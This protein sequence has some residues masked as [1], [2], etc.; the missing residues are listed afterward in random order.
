MRKRG[1]RVILS[2]MQPEDVATVPPAE[3]ALDVMWPAPD[4]QL[5]RVSQPELPLVSEA[6]YAAGGE[7]QAAIEPQVAQLE[8]QV[9][10]QLALAAADGPSVALPLSSEPQAG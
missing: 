10:P 7:A 8:A 9:A 6:D 4:A 3:P 1:R 5:S 2:R